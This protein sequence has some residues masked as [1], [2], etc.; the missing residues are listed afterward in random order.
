MF[1]ILTNLIDFSWLL[2]IAI[3]T[4]IFN[5][6]YHCVIR[7]WS[8]FNDRNVKFIR[9][10]PFFGSTYKIFFGMEAMNDVFET[11]YNK[12]PDESVIGMYELGGG[13]VYVIRDPD[14]IKQ[15]A[16]KDF[17]HFVNR[18]LAMSEE[19]DPLIGKVRFNNDNDMDVY[20]ELP[21]DYLYLQLD[22]Q[23]LYFVR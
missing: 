3:Y 17:D 15:I 16:I 19:T 10:I 21:S 20:I 11:L 1:Q 7:Y 14:M 13:P 6:V 2:W 12:Y 23:K 5:F 18:R 8:F 9:G 22:S 4:L